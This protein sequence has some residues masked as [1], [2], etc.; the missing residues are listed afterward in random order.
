MSL[1]FLRGQVRFMSARGIDVTAISSAGPDLD[2]FAESEGVMVA[3]VEMPRR[4]TPF[5]DLGAVT[6]LRRIMR[7]VRPDI[8]HAH[9][10]K[11]GLLGMIAAALAGVPVRIYHMRGLPMSTATGARRRLLSAT[12]WISCRLAHRVLCVSHSVRDEAVAE[13]LCPPGKIKVL[14]GGS[15]NGVDATG[16]FDPDKLEL[17]SRSLT[18]RRLGIPDDAIV[19]GFVG[20]LVRDKGIVELFDAWTRLREEFSTA[21]LLLVGPFEPRDPVPAGLESALREDPR[22]H[23]VGMDWNT[24]PLY[25]AMDLVVLPTYREG[26]PNVP[27]EAAAMR[28]PVVATRVPGCIDAVADGGTGVLVPAR[29]GPALTD[30]VRGYMRDPALRRAHGHAGRERVLREFRQEALWE[31]LHT[32]YEDLLAD[33]GVP[34]DTSVHTLATAGTGK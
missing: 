19:A 32:E 33:R 24:P 1:V 5:G 27:L 16:R 34:S 8:V 22:V 6:A 28:L 29:N 23:L 15:G 9:T 11:G 14:L 18:R 30:A 3:S 4:I 26:F 21:H 13:G 31:A 17:D 2:A 7:R 20:R 10:P 12:E 25:S